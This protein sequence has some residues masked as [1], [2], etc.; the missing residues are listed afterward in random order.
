MDHSDHSYIAALMS[1]QEN[2]FS[3]RK[4]AM[5]C[6]SAATDLMNTLATEW[7]DPAQLSR[8]GIQ[9]DR[10]FSRSR[11]MGSCTTVVR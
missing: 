10:A 6:M 8:G 3:S 9:D 5:D 11:T 1:L 2:A 4:F 7:S